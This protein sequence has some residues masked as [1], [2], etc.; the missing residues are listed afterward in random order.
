ML[1]RCCPTQCSRGETR[2]TWLNIPPRSMNRSYL[3]TVPSK[4]QASFPVADSPPH[5]PVCPPHQTYTEH[6]THRGI[7]LRRGHRSPRA[8]THP[9]G[10]QG[11]P[12]DKDTL[13]I[14]VGCYTQ[15]DSQARIGVD[16]VEPAIGDD[17][18]EFPF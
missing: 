1:D 18:A 7:F 6:I 17:R 11:S 9:R 4:T 5:R 13:L 3:P 12:G 14:T 8:D 15:V 2:R 16:R 10:S